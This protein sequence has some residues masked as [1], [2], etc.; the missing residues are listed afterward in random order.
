MTAVNTIYSY[1]RHQYNYTCNIMTTVNTIYI[2]TQ[3]I[4]TCMITVNTIITTQDITIATYMITVNT[5]TTLKTSL[6]C[7][8]GPA[9]INC[10]IT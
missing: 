8:T 1:T 4:T 5:I 2:A 7:V 6:Q 9:K 3:D 10:L